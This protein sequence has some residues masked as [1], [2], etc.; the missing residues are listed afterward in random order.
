MKKYV[1]VRECFLDATGAGKHIHYHPGMVVEAKTKP[2]H[3]VPVGEVKVDLSYSDESLLVSSGCEKVDFI[4]YAFEIF[5]IVIDEELTR[6]QVI[7]EFVGH[8]ENYL[9]EQRDQGLADM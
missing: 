3:F 2:P 9:E 5:G 4:D 8:R 1:C 6:K 7:K